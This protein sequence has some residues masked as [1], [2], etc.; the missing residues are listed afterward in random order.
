MNRK[1]MKAENV[2]YLSDYTSEYVDDLKSIST[3]EQFSIFLRK[4]DYWLDLEVKELAGADWTWMEQLVKDC[5]TD[6]LIPEEKH[7][8]AI[9]LT[10]LRI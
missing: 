2:T 6:G 8:I 4:W 1:T 10:I 5:R 3:P 9:Q 7:E